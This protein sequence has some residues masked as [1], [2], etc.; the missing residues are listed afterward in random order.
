MLVERKEEEITIE[1]YICDVFDSYYSE[2]LLN[3][4]KEQ[5]IGSL[6]N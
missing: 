6:G 5:L 2:F 1:D 4:R 3:F